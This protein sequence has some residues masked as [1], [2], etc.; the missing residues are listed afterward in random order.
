[1][2]YSV[3]EELDNLCQWFKPRAEESLGTIQPDNIFYMINKTNEYPALREYIHSGVST[4][5]INNHVA[6]VIESVFE[7]CDTRLED[8]GLDKFS[9]S[10]SVSKE[11]GGLVSSP[12]FYK[13][14]ICD[15]FTLIKSEPSRFH[16]TK[17]KIFTGDSESNCVNQ[18]KFI[19]F[20]LGNAKMMEDYAW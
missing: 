7:K 11:I 13:I 15:A 14:T 1:M 18:L 19:S 16:F 20:L 2:T 4:Q 6:Y 17:Q 9:V 10:I 8:M 3:E 12:S 5:E